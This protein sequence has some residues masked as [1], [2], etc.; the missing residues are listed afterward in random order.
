MKIIAKF[1]VAKKYFLNNYSI[2]AFKSPELTFEEWE[3][4]YDICQNNSINSGSGAVIENK[5]LYGLDNS[6]VAQN[7]FYLRQIYSKRKAEFFDLVNDI[8]EYIAADINSNS[9]INKYD[10]SI[11][12]L[13]VIDR[14]EICF[15]ENDTFCI[16]NG[17][18]KENLL[19]YYSNERD[20]FNIYYD[21]K[22]MQPFF[23]YEENSETFNDDV[24]F[25]LKRGEPYYKFSR[26]V[27]EEDLEKDYSLGKEI[28]IDTNTFPENVKIVGETYIRNKNTLKDERFQFVIEEAKIKTNSE[29]NLSPDG[30]PTVFD[31]NITIVN[32]ENEDLIK[33]IKYKVEKDIVNG[34]FRIVPEKNRYSQTLINTNI[35]EDID[36]ENKEIY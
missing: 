24:S 19:K 29:I 14:Y 10:M 5:Y 3:I 20:N 25:C 27:I 17:K 12:N 34:G 36:V 15:V 4:V 8:I 35:L 23:Y 31:M 9:K 18:Q 26:T 11:K 7:R 13:N 28:T 22:T 30:E 16:N 32:P 1:T 6:Y 2:Y 21:V 33:L